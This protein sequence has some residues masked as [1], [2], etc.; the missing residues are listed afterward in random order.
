MTRGG[1]E[2]SGSVAGGSAPHRPVLRTEVLRALAPHAGGVYVDG[3]FGA[4][5]YTRAI[6]ETPGTRVIALDRDPSAGHAAAA[7]AADHPDR[8][9]FREGRFGDLDAI[10]RDCGYDR[11]DGI[12]LDIGVSSMQLDQAERGFSFRHGPSAADIVNHTDETTLAAILYR[13]GDERESRRIARAVVHD[14]VTV[15]FTRTKALADLVG[16]VV[17]GAPGRVHPATR[18]FQALRIAVN[19][20]LGQLLH[21]LEAA[22]RVLGQ[23]GVLAVVTFHSLEDRIVKRFLSRAAGRAS[24]GS[25]HRP[26]VAAPTEPSFAAP[27]GQPVSAGSDEV[28]ANPRARSARLRWGVRTAAAALGL[29]D[30]LRALA[31]LGLRAGRPRR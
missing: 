23:N 6:L 15:P 26:D 20:E 12:A 31:D 24:G 29:D 25:R 8:F 28:D 4:G 11:V 17:R 16:R 19:D 10:V 9:I 13:F 21:G 5:G 3:T 27:A 22:E 7:V 2:P 30:D 1:D 18:T 14:R